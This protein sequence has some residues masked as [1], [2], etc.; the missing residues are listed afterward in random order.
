MNANFNNQLNLE[1]NNIT[2]TKGSTN[3]DKE[4]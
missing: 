4:K 3:I 2:P 1:S